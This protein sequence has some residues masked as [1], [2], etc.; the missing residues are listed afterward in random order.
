MKTKEPSK[1]KSYF[2]KETFIR[3]LNPDEIKKTPAPNYR[4]TQNIDLKKD[5]KERHKKEIHNSIDEMIKYLRLVERER[6]RLKKDTGAIDAL[7]TWLNKGLIKK[8]L[9]LKMKEAIENPEV[10]YN[11]TVT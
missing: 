7:N 2:K 5:M 9:Y 6:Y 10:P 3:G 4:N 1:A 8:E 11:I